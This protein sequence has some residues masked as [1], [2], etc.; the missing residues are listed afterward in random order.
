MP[1]IYLDY[2]ATAPVLPDVADVVARAFA[3]TGNPSSVH[4]AGTRAR[5]AVETARA[6][7]AAFVNAAPHQVLFTAS[8]SEAN[9]MVIRSFA[10]KKIL[11]GAA[12]HDSVAITPGDKT[13]I[14]LDG[15]GL[16]RMSALETLLQQTQPALVSVQWVNNETGVI[17]PIRDIA[18]LAHRYGAECHTDA[19]QAFGRIPLDFSNVSV[20]FMT[21]AFHKAGGP[22]GVAAVIGATDLLTPLVFGGTQENRR[23]AGTENVPLLAG[24]AALL[25]WYHD[26]S[27]PQPDALRRRITDLLPQALVFGGNAPHIGTVCCLAM[28]DVEA[29]TQLMAFDLAGIAVSAGAACASGKTEG[30]KT[31]RAM[32]IPQELATSAI[33]VSTGWQTTDADI[34]IFASEWKRLYE[35]THRSRAA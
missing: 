9:T 29:H 1:M 22:A 7:L 15:N 21:L 24:M 18:A 19:V 23:R 4:R 28:P 14:P 5:R 3:L 6:R 16:V 32:G 11:V 8:A 27:L 13:P 34:A 12:E 25:D 17:Q 2:N 31:L 20:D 26:T 35:R 10:G 33:R 30:P